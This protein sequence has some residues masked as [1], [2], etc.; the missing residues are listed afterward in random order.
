MIRTALK[1]IGPWIGKFLYLQLFISLIAF[2]LLLCWGLPI[3]LL[4]PVGNLI[5]GP[6]LTVFLFLSSMLFFTE[7]LY[8]P[9]GW[10]A[11]VLDTFTQSWL[12]LKHSRPPL[13]FWVCKTFN[14]VTYFYP[15]HSDSNN[16]F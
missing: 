4:S 9:N 6:F 3:S 1:K 16:S 10:I 5:F 14:G 2:P 11:S 8:L 12:S 13:A 7:L 15:V